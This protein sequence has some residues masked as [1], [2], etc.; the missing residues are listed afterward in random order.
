MGQYLSSDDTYK[1]TD[2]ARPRKIPTIYVDEFSGYIKI[3]GTEENTISECIG[4][5]QD[6][7]R[8]VVDINPNGLSF[9]IRC[10]PGLYTEYYDIE[11]EYNKYIADNF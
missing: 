2:N 4:Y 3:V 11:C 6:L 9:G 8:L 1:K 7:K 5:F 10:R